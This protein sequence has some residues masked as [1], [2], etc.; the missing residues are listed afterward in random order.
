MILCNSYVLTIPK[1]P[2]PPCFVALCLYLVF[3]TLTEQMPYQRTEWFEIII[4]G[5]SYEQHLIVKSNVSFCDIW[6][7]HF[8][9]AKN[10]FDFIYK[11]IMPLQIHAYLFS[12]SLREKYLVIWKRFFFFFC[13]EVRHR[14]Q[15][16]LRF[17]LKVIL[18]FRV[19]D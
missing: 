11:W 16:N 8:H 6:T 14:N 17:E 1:C 7:M 13:K 15:E 2:L 10:A 18:I 19:V 12:N 4:W 5:G 9:K 3:L